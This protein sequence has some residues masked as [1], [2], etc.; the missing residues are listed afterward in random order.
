MRKYTFPGYVSDFTPLN[1]IEST[2]MWDRDKDRTSHTLVTNGLDWSKFIH[3]SGWGLFLLTPW[4]R[5]DL[6]DIR[7]V[8]RTRAFKKVFVNNPPFN[9]GDNEVKIFSGSGNTRNQF[10]RFKKGGKFVTFSIKGGGIDCTRGH[11]SDYPGSFRKRSITTVCKTP[12]NEWCFSFEKKTMNSPYS[13]IGGMEASNMGDFDAY[14]SFFSKMSSTVPAAIKRTMAQGYAVV[15]I[16]FI[17]VKGIKQDFFL[18]HGAI[19]TLLDSELERVDENEYMFQAV[20]WSEAESSLRWTA[21]LPLCSNNGNSAENIGCTPSDMS[22]AD[23]FCKAEKVDE[24]TYRIKTYTNHPNKRGRQLKALPDFCDDGKLKYRVNDERQIEVCTDSDLEYDNRK[25]SYFY[26]FEKELKEWKAV[27]DQVLPDTDVPLPSTFASKG[28]NAK[29]AYKLLYSLLANLQAFIQ[30]G[31]SS[32]PGGESFDPRNFGVGPRDS[33]DW[34]TPVYLVFPSFL[35]IFFILSSSHTHLLSPQVRNELNW[36][37]VV[38]D[39]HTDL[40][41][42]RIA[43]YSLPVMFG[44]CGD[45]DMTDMLSA[46]KTGLDVILRGTYLLGLSFI[47]CVTMNTHTHTHTHTQ[48]RYLQPSAHYGYSSIEIVEAHV[49]TY[50]Q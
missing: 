31:F 6:F 19:R 39:G 13:V 11:L 20:T 29:V 26:D 24:E 25:N 16:P 10:Q 42:V 28:N 7:E 33:G 5:N 4:Q 17:Y 18:R 32:S 47:H 37:V 30:S 44:L 8:K 48:K 40:A 46:V 1:F 21:K 45:T 9:I 12:P 22:D 3:P 35:S 38:Y 15:A 27:V 50:R 36:G 41:D 49:Q 34:G 43:L 23:R 2:G 14:N